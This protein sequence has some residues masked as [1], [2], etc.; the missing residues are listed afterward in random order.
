MQHEQAVHVHTSYEYIYRSNE[1]VRVFECLC[2]SDRNR[3]KFPYSGSWT[4]LDT[5]Q[6]LLLLVYFFL[7]QIGLWSFTRPCF[8]NQF[9]FVKTWYCI[10]NEQLIYSNLLCLLCL[11]CLFL[12]LYSAYLHNFRVSIAIF[13]YFAYT[14]CSVSLLLFLLLLFLNKAIVCFFEIRWS[15]YLFY[16]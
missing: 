9:R 2:V 10:I 15:K 1:W 14:L 8:V 6:L 7:F 12:F 4:V 16:L 5:F 11:F 3:K 13:V